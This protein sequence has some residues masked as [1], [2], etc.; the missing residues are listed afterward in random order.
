MKISTLIY[1]LF[2]ILIFSIVQPLRGQSLTPN[3]LDQ[4]ITLTAENVTIAELLNGISTKAN[5]KFSYNPKKIQAN[6]RVSVESDALPVREVLNSIFED[7]FEFKLRGNYVIIVPRE[8]DKLEQRKGQ[9]TMLSGYI[10]DEETKDGIADVSVFSSS[11]SN[12]ITDE[13]GAF[14]IKLK[15]DE[16][17]VVQLRKKGFEPLGY[18]SGHTSKSNVNINMRPIKNLSILIERTELKTA[19]IASTEPKVHLNTIFPINESL[20]THQENITDSL[21]RPVSV[22]LYPGF[23]T[24]SNLSGI[25]EF[26]FALNFVGY[27]RGINGLEIG[28]LSNINKENVRGATFAGLSSYVGGNI[29]GV[30]TS[31]IFNVTGGNILGLQAAGI[32]NVTLG[33]I[34][35]VQLSGI[36]NFSRGNI[37]GLQAAGIF[38]RADSL[39]GLQ[40]SGILNSSKSITGLQAAGIANVS[41]RS[42]GLQVAGIVNLAKEVKGAQV[43]GILNLGG[44]VQGSQ[45]GLINVSDSISGIP[46]GLLSFVRKNGYK[47]IEVYADELFPVNVA[48]RTGVDRFHN[49]LIAGAQTDIFSNENSFYTFGYGVGSSFR[50]SRLFAIDLDLTSQVITKQGFTDTES[51]RFKSYLGLDINLTN[52]LSVV[53]GASFNAYFV[54]SALLVDEDFNQLRSS[55]LFGEEIG[56]SGNVW[57]GW[58]G[59]K[60]GLRYGF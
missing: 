44:N 10:L 20:K 22:S 56:S 11:G 35:G 30:Q 26:N 29:K 13:T 53:G 45:I 59:F 2:S 32:S 46:I 38:N 18:E 36:S 50:L 6:K 3:N 39:Q 48:F 28:A 41:A 5:I 54:D 57:R 9:E 19:P 12:T 49:I 25:T 34:E 16:N 58:I 51:L 33:D 55:Y 17:S 42:E 47:K 23:S 1:I 52:S 21:T 43:A 8:E 4:K 60:G 14:S 40:L 31:G 27:N 24:S 7:A 37:H 15:K